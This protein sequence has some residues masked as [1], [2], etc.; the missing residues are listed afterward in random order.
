MSISSIVSA[1]EQVG[2][3][4]PSSIDYA[5]NAVADPG[6]P[7]AVVEVPKAFAIRLAGPF[8]GPRFT[9]RVSGER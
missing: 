1:G 5:K 9:P 6:Q 4:Y 2:S 7:S 8:P 3:I